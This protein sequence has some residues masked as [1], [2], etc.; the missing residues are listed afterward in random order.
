MSNEHPVYKKCFELAQRLTPVPPSIEE[1]T[2]WQ[3][4]FEPSES[5]VIWQ[6]SEEQPED[7]SYTELTDADLVAEDDTLPTGAQVIEVFEP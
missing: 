3:Q 6:Q 7:D 1:R 5:R 4:G 2:R